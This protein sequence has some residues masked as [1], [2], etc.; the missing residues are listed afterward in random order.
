MKLV[1]EHG[2]AW[3]VLHAVRRDVSIGEVKKLIEN[4]EGIPAEQQ[5]LVIG[6]DVL[7]EEITLRVEFRYLKER[8][9]N[10]ETP[11]TRMA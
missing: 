4:Q 11:R 5:V 8:S 3:I 9:S 10:T 7:G 2:Y 1:I 6:G